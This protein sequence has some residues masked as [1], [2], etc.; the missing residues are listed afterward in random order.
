MTI[1]DFLLEN[2]LV[3]DALIRTSIRQRLRNTL[4]EHSPTDQKA[5]T[6]AMEQL[7]NE[8]KQSPIAINTFDANEQHYE[9]PAEFYKIVL[10]PQLKYSCGLWE[11]ESDD[12]ESSELQMLELTTERADIKN[13]TK[14]LDLGCGWGSFSLFAA[15]KFPDKKFTAV[16][17][18]NSQREFIEKTAESRGIKNL[19]V[20][21]SDINDFDPDEKFD[22]VVSVEMFE[23]VRNY[24]KLFKK[25]HTWLEKGGKLFVHIFNHKKIAYKFEIKDSSDWM[26]R[27]FFTG[28]MMPSD[29]LLMQFSEGF[30]LDGH[31][32][33]NGTH[34][35]KTLEAWLQKMDAS[36]TEVMRLFRNT[37]NGQAGK[38]WV[39][40]RVFFM[41]C[42][43]T[44]RMDG[45][46]QWQVSHYVF[47]RD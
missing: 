21:T 46:N 20:I 17:N 43:E 34:Y 31:W 23:H 3:P 18:S 41:A 32:N 11:D 15:T 16:S 28:G 14:I 12:L 6:A 2:N 38:F 29:G 22:R 45:G 26:A 47:V 30:K 27:H 9:V 25:I 33:V 35:S 24:Q 39:Y 44:F 1:T 8:L 13:G 37:Y 5:A 7:V 4:K 19:K 36:K 10:G 42:S 40:W